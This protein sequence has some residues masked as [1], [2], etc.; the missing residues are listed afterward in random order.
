MQGRAGGAGCPVPRR[1]HLTV[2]L[3]FSL[4]PY[5]AALPYPTSGEAKKGMNFSRRIR[6][7][8]GARRE[9]GG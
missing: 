6:P 4:V 8:V 7:Q 5:V 2:E 1:V 9:E 3:T